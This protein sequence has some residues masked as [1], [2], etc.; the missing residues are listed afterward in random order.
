LS[1]PQELEEVGARTGTMA[2]NDPKMVL[3]VEDELLVR[4]ATSQTLAEA[5]YLILEAGTGDEALRIITAG[6]PL[7]AVVTDIEMP[8]ALDGL[9]LAKAIETRWPEIAI[10][11]ISGRRLPAPDEL[12]QKAVFL[13]KPYSPGR[14]IAAVGAAL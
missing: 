6:A 9:E 7:S 12:P 11:I 1:F 2:A 3:V 10:V 4:V 5:G 13:P 8:G 14:L